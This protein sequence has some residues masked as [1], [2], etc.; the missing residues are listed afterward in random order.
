MLLFFRVFTNPHI[1]LF[2]Y[3]FHFKLKIPTHQLSLSYLILFFSLEQMEQ[4]E[5]MGRTI[6]VKQFSS[7]GKNSS[8]HLSQTSFH[9]SHYQPIP[10]TPLSQS[11]PRLPGR[12]R[13][14]AVAM[15]CRRWF[16][17]F[18]QGPCPSS[19]RSLVR[20]GCEGRQWPRA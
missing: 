6:F 3:L 4:M 11:R 17:L 1:H 18:A 10:F 16:G 8:D 19:Q 2:H 7:R 12:R 13:I 20:Y 14:G 9:P 5:Q 15:F